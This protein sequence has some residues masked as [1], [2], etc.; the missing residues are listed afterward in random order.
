MNRAF[1]KHYKTQTEQN[2]CELHPSLNKN[3][4]W[5]NKVFL[6]ILLIIP[7][8]ITA[9][10]MPV[11]S[12][13]FKNSIF[14]NPSHVGMEN[15]LRATMQYRQQWVGISGAPETMILSLDGGVAE[16]MGLGLVVYNDATDIFSQTGFF[17]DYS[18]N[19]G[20]RK[21]HKIRLGLGFGVVQNR[22]DYTKITA[23]Y[24]N[25][26]N[27]LNYSEKGSKIDAGFGLRYSFKK[28]YL[29]FS[30]SNLLNN[31]YMYDDQSNF[32][33]N[34][35]RMV[36]HFV[37][38]IGYSYAVPKTSFNCDPWIALR[39]VQGSTAQLEGNLSVT[40]KNN[41]TLTGGYR[42][43]AGFYGCVQFKIFERFNLGYVYDFPNRYLNSVVSGSNEILISYRFARKSG[44]SGSR[45]VS[46]D[47][48]KIQKQN[49]E[50]FQ[51][52]EKLQQENERLVKQLANTEDKLSNQKEELER[53]K[54]IFEKDKGEMLRVKEKYE[55]D[56]SEIDS[57]ENSNDSIS[58][59]KD[60]YIILGAY[61]TL[62]DAKF[63][64]KILERELGLQTLVFE[65]EDSKYFFVY[66]KKVHS[67]DDVNKEFRRLKRMNI[68]EFI[69]GNLWIYGE[70]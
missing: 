30:V 37:S 58:S 23:D 52:I 33:T 29:D 14:Y 47:L 18:Y 6:T 49:Q 53:L 63:F 67:R 68:G 31:R 17:G 35:F 36:N 43:D 46:S 60:Y 38:A 11:M 48:K 5:M 41:I 40:Y 24:P 12:T 19:L 13:S 65:R 42:Q 1:T 57:I 51:E 3:F 64:Q 27:I 39:S 21:S 20:L 26:D 15:D 62:A 56:I 70:K 59:Q 45:F 55:I 25:E 10:Q 32:R 66:T 7:L 34:K 4:N 50:Q 22:I 44:T 69:N 61:L 2:I 9:Q 8:I 54:E 28:L 16:N